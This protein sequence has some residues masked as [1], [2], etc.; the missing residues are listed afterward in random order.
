M[1]F[2]IALAAVCC[3]AFSMPAL[4]Q[5][6]GP[7]GRGKASDSAPTQATEHGGDKGSKG[8]K[9]GKGRT[10][11]RREQD[12]SVPV[13]PTRASA[14]RARPIAQPDYSPRIATGACPPGLA[15]KNNGCLPPGQARKL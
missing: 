14:D 10:S 15:N 7:L 9:G 2:S 13:Q 8:S 1:K 11:A 5:K 4:A 12:R 6:D 3:A